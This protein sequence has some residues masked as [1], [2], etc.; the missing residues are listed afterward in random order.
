MG[1]ADILFQWS[2][3]D[4]THYP[5]NPVLTEM[6]NNCL[7]KEGTVSTVSNHGPGETICKNLQC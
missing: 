7:L 4:T 6:F 1:P 2:N 5:V 3:V